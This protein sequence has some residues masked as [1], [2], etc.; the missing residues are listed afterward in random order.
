MSPRTLIITACTVM[1]LAA[2]AVA[3]AKALPTTHVTNHPRLGKIA[4]PGFK[5]HGQPLAPVTYINVPTSGTP[6][7]LSQ[8]GLCNQANAEL[9]AQVLHATSCVATVGAPSTTDTSA[10]PDDQSQPSDPST[11]TS[12]PDSAVSLVA[13]ATDDPAL[14]FLTWC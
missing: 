11:T 1:A 8:S 5:R 3:G 12:G 4:K 10:A 14:S 13:S 7:V 6:T 2:P 9:I